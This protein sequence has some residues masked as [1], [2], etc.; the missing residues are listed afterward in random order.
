[1]RRLEPV[2]RFKEFKICLLK[3]VQVFGRSVR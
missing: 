3:F 2:Q 1:M